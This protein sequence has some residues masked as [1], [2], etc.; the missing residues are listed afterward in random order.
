MNLQKIIFDLDGTLINTIGGI[1]YSANCVLKSY[2]Y[3]VHHIAKYK[4]YVGYGLKR[5]LYN[6]LPKEAKSKIDYH[7]SLMEEMYQELLTCY[8]IHFLKDTHIYEGIN[9]LLDYLDAIK[10]P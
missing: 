8:D 2:G 7:S 1:G 4:Q 9:E 3:P 6:A 5:T 10:L